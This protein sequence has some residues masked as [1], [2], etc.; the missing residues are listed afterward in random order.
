MGQISDVLLTENLQECTQKLN[1]LLKSKNCRLHAPCINSLIKEQSTSEIKGALLLALAKG[2]LY[3]CLLKLLPYK[4]IEKHT[5]SVP[6][7]TIPF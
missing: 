1:I 7:E 5:L 2:N 3:I 6:R 4:V